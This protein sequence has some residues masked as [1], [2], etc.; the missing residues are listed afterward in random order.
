MKRVLI[1]NLTRM[2]DL[3]MTTPLIKNLKTKHPGSQIT[4]L[5]NKKFS[6]V[7]KYNPF[8]DHLYELDVHQFD[9]TGKNREISYLEVFRYLNELLKKCGPLILISLLTLHIPNYQRFY[10]HF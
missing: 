4:V 5:S 3:L 8:I 2:G 9:N 7:C 1:L 6:E 10:R